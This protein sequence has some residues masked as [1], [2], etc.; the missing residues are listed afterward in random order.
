MEGVG[1]R[2]VLDQV[3]N[4]SGRKVMKVNLLAQRD[5]DLDDDIVHVHALEKKSPQRKAQEQRLKADA[6][7]T[8]IEESKKKTEN[9]KQMVDSLRDI[10]PFYTDALLATAATKP[11]VA[12]NAEGNIS[13]DSTMAT[14]EAESASLA[15]PESP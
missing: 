12:T 4:T 2:P 8:K 9:V 7:R 5:D 15:V 13:Y 3:A 14:F 10:S 1:L 6:Y 11:N